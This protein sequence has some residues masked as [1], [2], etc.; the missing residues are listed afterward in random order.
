VS[1]IYDYLDQ[2]LIMNATEVKPSLVPEF[3]K[4]SGKIISSL[5]EK[6]E[7]QLISNLR[8]RYTIKIN[9]DVL[10]QVKQKFEK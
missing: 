6:R 10:E 3:N 2:Y 8:D 1:K 7:E 5:Q 4:V 9:K